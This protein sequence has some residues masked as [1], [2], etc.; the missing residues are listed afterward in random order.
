MH[1]ALEGIYCIRTLLIIKNLL[2]SAAP[3]VKLFNTITNRKKNIFIYVLN[4]L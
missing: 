1:M 3:A 4:T 2:H